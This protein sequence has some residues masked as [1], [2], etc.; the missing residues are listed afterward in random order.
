MS[1]EPEAR[2]KEPVTLQEAEAAC[3]RLDGEIERAR[4]VLSDY[5][6]SLGVGLSDNDNR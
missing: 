5:R 6:A 1:R 3:E 2:P 4:K